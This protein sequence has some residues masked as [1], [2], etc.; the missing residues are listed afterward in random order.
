[1]FTVVESFDALPVDSDDEAM[2]FCSRENDIFV[3]KNGAW[4]SYE[5]FVGGFEEIASVVLEEDINVLDERVLF[6][7]VPFYEDF[8]Y[9]VIYP[10][11]FSAESFAAYENSV[12]SFSIIK[13]DTSF[14]LSFSGEKIMAP[15][16]KVYYYIRS[17][18]NDSD[19]L[20]KIKDR[21]YV[22][23][24]NVL[25]SNISIVGPCKLTLLKPI[26]V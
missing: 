12:F 9:G 1:M 25:V 2:F 24:F 19:A 21:S 20:E 15:N 14:L 17:Q 26:G 4:V 23:A 16:F 5:A 6:Q 3:N 13:Q 18:I 8:K 22:D 10:V 11:T 7:D